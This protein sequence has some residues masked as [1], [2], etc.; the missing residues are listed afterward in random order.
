MKD[1]LIAT[2]ILIAALAIS[3]FLGR[4]SK[5]PE[6]EV[7][8]QTDTLV[9]RDTIHHDRPVYISQKVVDTLY[10]P[11]TDTIH[12]HDTTFVVLPRTQR[13]YSDST[14]RAWVSGYDPRLDSISV[15]RQTVYV[16]KIQT[17]PPKRWHLG[18]SAGYGLGTSG[19]T[20]YVGVGI[21]YSLLSF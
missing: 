21:T 14:Y 15:Y 11:L 5:K 12:R 2:L 13:E 4:Y 16:T 6:K 17:L 18:V 7:V 20:P 9:I 10:I 1:T 3:F 8:V 19:L